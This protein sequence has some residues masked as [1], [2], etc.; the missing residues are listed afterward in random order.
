MKPTTCLTE[1]RMGSANAHA[2][3]APRTRIASISAGSSIRRVTTLV[4]TSSRACFFRAV[5]IFPES[6]PFGSTLLQFLIS[7]NFPGFSE[8]RFGQRSPFI[9]NLSPSGR[10]MGLKVY[11]R[12]RWEALCFELWRFA[13]RVG[14]PPMSGRAGGI[15]DG[16]RR[17]S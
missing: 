12:V 15:E 7:N 5:L 9:V 17:W 3:S 16:S 1:R 4:L 8:N 14:E 11:R 10:P 13:Q 6:N 2:R